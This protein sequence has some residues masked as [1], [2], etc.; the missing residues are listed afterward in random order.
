MRRFLKKFNMRKIYKNINI[1]LI[2]ML[3]WL[4]LG[5]DAA[6]A[7]RPPLQ[8]GSRQKLIAMDV[9][10]IPPKADIGEKPY[11]LLKMAQAGLN[12]P[13]F[14]IIIGNGRGRLT[15]T[16]KLKAFF[17]KLHKPVLVR[18][19]HKDEGAK[20]SFSGVF[21]SYKNINVIKPT[22]TE[23]I[24]E[25]QEGYWE[26]G[27]RPESLQSAYELIVESA[28]EYNKIKEY[29]QDHNITDFNPKQ[30]NVVVMEQIDVEVF[31]MFLTSS[32]N[33][34]D[35]VCIHYQIMDKAAD[36]K[37]AEPPPDMLSIDLNLKEKGGVITYNKR[38]RELGKNELDEKTRDVLRQFGE[39]AGQIEKMFGVQQIELGA[40]NGKVYVFQSRD[41]NLANPMDAPRFGY[42]KTM[43]EELLAIGYGYYRLPVL[44]IDSLDK[45]HPWFKES[46]EFR[47]VSSLFSSIPVSQEEERRKAWQACYNLVQAERDKYKEEILRFAER[48]PEYILVIKDAE[49]VV[50]IEEYFTV[51][52]S[53]DFLNL[54]ISKAKVQIRGRNQNAIRHEDWDNV[55]L[56]GITIIPPEEVSGR[57]G[58]MEHF[59]HI[60]DNRFDYTFNRPSAQNNNVSI[61]IPGRIATGDFLNVLS[62]IDG[63]FVWIDER[64][65]EDAINF[66]QKNRGQ[67]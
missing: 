14:F 30:M 23:I 29:L 11:K 41:I 53:Y 24:S 60:K 64:G 31:G 26:H 55:E 4:F 8:M 65:A 58:F 56:G 62:N 12:V 15:I 33:N 47:K 36:E 21:E 38:T 7:L 49:A 57:G 3:G 54:L 51:S 44:V 19:A 42:Y 34:P 59:V 63:V 61:Q 40:S 43:S 25:E 32:Q 66:M 48:N 1:V 5:T 50:Y 16:D 28:T 6:Y 39:T 35:E 67:L 17:D 2:F 46:D 13:P 9:S 37:Q 45:A 20:Y 22:P 27:F 18:S 52:E 10:K